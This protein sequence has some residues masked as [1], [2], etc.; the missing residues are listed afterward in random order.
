[1]ASRKKITHKTGR[2]GRK[3]RRSPAK[4]LAAERALRA[5]SLA[6]DTAYHAGKINSAEAYRRH[7]AINRRLS[8]LADEK[9]RPFFRSGETVGHVTQG[10]GVITGIIPADYRSSPMY[11]VIRGQERGEEIHDIWPEETIRRRQGR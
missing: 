8:D 5:A 9:S 3:K 1:M 4:I 11:R 10:S 6:A 2:A 7:I